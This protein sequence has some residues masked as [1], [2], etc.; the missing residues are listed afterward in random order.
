MTLLLPTARTPD[1]LRFL[2]LPLPSPGCHTSPLSRCS[3]PP[4]QPLLGLR[5]RDCFEGTAQVFCR[6]SITLGLSHVCLVCSLVRP[7]LRVCGDSTPQ[8]RRP[9]IALYRGDLTSA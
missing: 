4:S 2:P 3:V 7:G 1:F 9:L 6:A 5:G 8:V